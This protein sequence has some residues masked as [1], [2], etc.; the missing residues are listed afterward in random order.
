MLCTNITEV[1]IRFEYY[2]TILLI[3]ILNSLTQEFGASGLVSLALKMGKLVHQV[4]ILITVIVT[5]LQV[6]R[7]S[8]EPRT[9]TI[10]IM[11]GNTRENNATIFVP[12]FVATMEN[13][14]NQMRTS[15][16]GIAVTGSGLDANYGLAQCYGDLSLLDC[17]LC[18]A[19]ARTVLPQC[20]PVNG[21]RIYLEGCYM[22]SQNFSFFEEYTGPSDTA[23][24]GNTTLKNNAFQETARRAVM[25]A[26]TDA[27]RNK[28][29]YFARAKMAVPRAA[30]ES[31]YVLADCWRTL[32]E[33]SC[34][35]C[36]ENASASILGC[37]PWSE[38]H[39]LNT[40]CYMRYSDT[41]FL[42]PKPS[43]GN[44]RGDMS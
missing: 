8:G 16:Y 29:Y 12:N 37:L 17:V 42:N 27:T 25:S 10:R 1:L 43:N 20:F 22:R 7:S 36:L 21:G 5:L 23:V 30:N 19:E 11:C 26:V 15:G 32:N 38:G 2:I 28:N 34:R 35:A 39:A 31:A 33:S 40:G 14:S 3:S 9:K 13:I 24:C 6:D 18:Y 4:S 44:S 41:N